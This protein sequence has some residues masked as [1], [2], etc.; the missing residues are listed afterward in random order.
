M[1]FANIKQNFCKENCLQVNKVKIVFDS[2]ILKDD[3]TPEEA[4]LEDGDCIDIYD[5]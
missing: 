1:K 3:V 5:S 4:G 2:E